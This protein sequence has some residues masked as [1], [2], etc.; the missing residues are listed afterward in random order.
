[1]QLSKVALLAILGSASF[2]VATATDE[3]KSTREVIRDTCFRGPG[4]T[5][6]VTQKC[7]TNVPANGVLVVQLTSS[8]RCTCTILLRISTATTTTTGAG[9]S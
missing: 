6:L 3:C 7:M 4:P 1:M 2:L 8:S 9:R 5:L